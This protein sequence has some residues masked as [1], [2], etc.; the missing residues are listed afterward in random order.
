VARRDL[1]QIYRE[2]LFSQGNDSASTLQFQLALRAARLLES[3]KAVPCPTCLWP[4]FSSNWRTIGSAGSPD[5]SREATREERFGQRRTANRSSPVGLDYCKANSR[6]Q[7]S[8]AP[9]TPADTKARV[10]FGLLRVVETCRA[11]TVAHQ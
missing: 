11:D 9:A 6:H 8:R 3:L 7:L 10:L 4:I 1:L 2:L 5:R